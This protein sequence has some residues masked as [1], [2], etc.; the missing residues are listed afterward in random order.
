M[1]MHMLPRHHSIVRWRMSKLNHNFK[2]KHFTVNLF[3]NWFPCRLNLDSEF[4][5]YGIYLAIV[6]LPLWAIFHPAYS[7]GL[8]GH[9]GQ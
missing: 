3:I 1:C 5:H 2:L 7:L 6:G 9:K 8:Y 4:N